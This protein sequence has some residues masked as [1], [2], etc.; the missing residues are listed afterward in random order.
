MTRTASPSASSLNINIAVVYLCSNVSADKTQRQQESE[1]RA[2][3]AHRSIGKMREKLN[4]NRLFLLSVLTR[5]TSHWNL[6]TLISSIGCFVLSYHR[7]SSFVCLVRDTHTQLWF[8]FS[9]NCT[10]FFFISVSLIHRLR[11]V[12]RLEGDSQAM[13]RVCHFRHFPDFCLV[14]SLTGC[15]S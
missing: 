3:G 5:F 10:H 11:E 14:I 6:L 13:S 8:L 9:G 7:A 1:R 15:S 2:G 4:I 12:R